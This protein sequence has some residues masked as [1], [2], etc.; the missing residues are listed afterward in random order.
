MA[1]Y[2]YIVSGAGKDLWVGDDGNFE[3]LEIWDKITDYKV[4]TSFKAAKALQ[5]AEL[6]KHGYGCNIY[7][8]EAKFPHRYVGAVGL[9]YVKEG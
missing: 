9:Q 6:L 2:Y 3:L 1:R 4:E 7:Q 8:F 5:G